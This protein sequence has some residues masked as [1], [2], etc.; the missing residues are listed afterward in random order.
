MNVLPRD[1]ITKPVFETGIPGLDAV[2]HLPVPLFPSV[3]IPLFSSVD[4]F[5]VSPP[6][7]DAAD[8]EEGAG[9]PLLHVT[10]VFLRVKTLVPTGVVKRDRDVFEERD[11]PGGF[12][13]VAMG[14]PGIEDEAIQ[15]IDD[16]DGFEVV[17]FPELSSDAFDIGETSRGLHHAGAVDDGTGPGFHNGC[18]LFEEVAVPA[19]RKALEAFLR[20]RVVR[21]SGESECLLELVEFIQEVS[22]FPVALLLYFF[23]GEAEQMLMDCVGSLGELT[24]I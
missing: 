21:H 15:G 22:V 3:R 10:L 6:F 19:W 4:L 8:I 2:P 13:A 16:K 23:E 24:A 18:E 14:P 9:M 1:E 5:S 11:E 17:P 7:G 20:C 12:M